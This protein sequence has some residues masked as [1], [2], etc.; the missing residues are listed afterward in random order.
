MTGNRHLD[1]DGCHNVRDFGGLRAAHGRETRSGAVVRGD[2]V[3]RL[4]ATGWSALLEHGI[5]TII[6]LRNDHVSQRKTSRPTTH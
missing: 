1:W 2:S 5:R 4:T 3:D 6:D